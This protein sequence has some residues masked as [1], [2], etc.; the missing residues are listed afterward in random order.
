[1]KKSKIVCGHEVIFTNDSLGY[2][3]ITI[4]GEPFIEFEDSLGFGRSFCSRLG[5]LVFD[6]IVEHLERFYARGGRAYCDIPDSDI[7]DDLKKF[8]DY[9]GSVDGFMRRYRASKQ[10]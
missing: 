4:G 2:A 3:Y 9:G 5:V 8:M 1:M 10:A 7:P 6:S